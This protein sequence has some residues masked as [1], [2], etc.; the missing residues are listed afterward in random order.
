MKF[1][2]LEKEAALLKGAEESQIT[3]SKHKEVI[4]R[5]EEKQWPS[6]KA[7][8]KQQGKYRRGVAVKMGG[9]NLCVRCVS[10][11]QDCLVHHSC[12]KLTTL[13][14]VKRKNLV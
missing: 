13:E 8:E 4:A 12:Y 3:G 7:R 2:T 14:L 11:R 5:D 9:T 6:K 1:V 10:A